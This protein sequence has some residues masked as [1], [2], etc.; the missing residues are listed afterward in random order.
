MKFMGPSPSAIDAALAKWHE[1]RAAAEAAAAAAADTQ[2]WDGTRGLESFNL[3]PADQQPEGVVERS[4]ADMALA[5]AFPTQQVP[6]Q[7]CFFGTC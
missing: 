3:G 5:E 6:D 7:F 2:P 1:E 4:L